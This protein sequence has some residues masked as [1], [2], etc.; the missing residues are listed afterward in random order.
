M[1]WS[2]ILENGRLLWRRLLES[3]R[4]EQHE[5]TPES[6][7]QLEAELDLQGWDRYDREIAEI[8]AERERNERARRPHEHL[9][10][11]TADLDGQ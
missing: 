7:S 4:A 5:A 11:D 3:G 9:R 6:I 2:L 1:E 8:Q 10:F